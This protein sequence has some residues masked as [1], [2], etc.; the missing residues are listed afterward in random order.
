MGSLFPNLALVMGLPSGLSHAHVYQVPYRSY[1]PPLVPGKTFR[2][3]L[4]L[5][6]RVPVPSLYES[7][8]ITIPSMDALRFLKQLLAFDSEDSDRDA[9]V[10]CSGVV[11]FCLLVFR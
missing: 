2:K 7:V 3:D 8:P 11:W 1:P 6:I 4:V 10:M 5:K 9:T